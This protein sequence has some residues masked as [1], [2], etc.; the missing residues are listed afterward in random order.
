M[1]NTLIQ[2]NNEIFDVRGFLYLRFLII[3]NSE[4]HIN[5]KSNLNE[6]FVL[7]CYKRIQRCASVS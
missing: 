1:K 3:L 7:R 5:F 4:L 6:T 2:N